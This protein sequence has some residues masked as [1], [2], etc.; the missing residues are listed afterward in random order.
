MAAMVE[1]DHRSVGG[2][3]LQVEHEVVRRAR[4]PVAEHELGAVVG[5]P[6]V[7]GQLH[8]VDREALAGLDV[9]RDTGHEGL[10]GVEAHRP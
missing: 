7:P 2:Q 3:G 5:T 10:P 4:E 1:A 9:E 8:P 6:P